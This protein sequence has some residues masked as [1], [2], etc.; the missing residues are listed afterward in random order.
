MEKLYSCQYT[1]IKFV[2]DVIK[3]EPINIGLFLYCVEK[4]SLI[5]D[6]SKEKI[7]ILPILNPGLNTSIVNAVAE[8]LKSMFEKEGFN[9][10]KLLEKLSLH[11]SQLKFTYPKGV[12]TD[13]PQLEFQKLF[14]EYVR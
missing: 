4:N 6:F 1:V 12:L 3:D 13:N 10:P 14:K 9:H 11:A 5:C 7:G 8:D 2:P